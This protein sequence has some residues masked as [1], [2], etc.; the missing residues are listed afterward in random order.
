MRLEV[1]DVVRVKDFGTISETLNDDSDTYY[2]SS[3]GTCHMHFAED[4]KKYCGQAYTIVSIRDGVYELSI[5]DDTWVFVEKW[6][7]KIEDE[8]VYVSDFGNDEEFE[9][10]EEQ[11]KKV[12]SDNFIKVIL[13]LQPQIEKCSNTSCD[14]CELDECIPNRL[15]NII[16]KYNAAMKIPNKYKE[17]DND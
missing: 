10:R 11:I 4:M 8:A 6:L 2:T 3:D 1:G 16:R 14:E 12:C 7:T 17:N 13:A 9:I 5:L 15:K